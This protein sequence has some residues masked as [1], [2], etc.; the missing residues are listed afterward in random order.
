MRRVSQLP[1]APSVGFME[2]LP[3]AFGPEADVRIA[4]GTYGG[5]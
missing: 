3:A 1:G 4:V 2:A 5:G